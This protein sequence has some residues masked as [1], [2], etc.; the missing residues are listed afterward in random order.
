MPASEMDT[1]NSGKFTT[2]ANQAVNDSSSSLSTGG[3]PQTTER[4][5]DPPKNEQDGIKFPQE[6]LDMIWEEALEPWLKKRVIVLDCLNDSRENVT[7]DEAHA[8]RNRQQVFIGCANPIDFE[9]SELVGNIR[10]VDRKARDTVRSYSSKFRE[11]FPKSRDISRR[12][13]HESFRAQHADFQRDIFWLSK[14]SLRSR[15]QYI[16]RSYDQNKLA[17]KLLQPSHMMLSLR[18]MLAL[19]Q[20][21]F[22]RDTPCIGTRHLDIRGLGDP[23]RDFHLAVQIDGPKQLQTLTVLLPQNIDEW[24]GKVEYEDLEHR[25]LGTSVEDKASMLELARTQ[26]ARGQLEKIY[27]YWSNLISLAEADNSDLPTLQ[28]S[29]RR[30]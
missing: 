21:V 25:P 23:L 4:P 16:S 30:L 7:F 28:F 10:L 9:S 1:A 29:R 18:H 2:D 20:M 17:Q 5:D 6:I 12:R 22:I 26:E 3:E 24:S 14:E 11:M 27:A 8:G 13:L 19:M 15:F